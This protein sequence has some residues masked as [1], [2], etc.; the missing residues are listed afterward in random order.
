[1]VEQL[2]KPWSL[3]LSCDLVDQES[4]RFCGICWIEEESGEVEMFGKRT[5]IPT[6][7]Q[8]PLP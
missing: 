2:L 8:K 5:I 6:L 7:S 3:I 4:G 1:M